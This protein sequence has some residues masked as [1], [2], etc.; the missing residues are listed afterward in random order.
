MCQLLLE[1]TNLGI[2]NLETHMAITMVG[3][4]A[5]FNIMSVEWESR[6]RLVH[7]LD[8]LNNRLG[9][10]LDADNFYKS[11]SSTYIF[12]TRIKPTSTLYL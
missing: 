6:S 2:S 8:G 9:V 11:N 4:R 3:G 10:V 5:P 12:Q 1:V 7:H